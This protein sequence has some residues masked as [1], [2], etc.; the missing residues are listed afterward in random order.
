MMEDGHCVR[1]YSLQAC[2][3]VDPVRNEVFQATTLRMLIQMVA[4]DLGI[5]LM[6]RSPLTR[7]LPRRATSC[8]D[9]SLRTSR[10]GPSRWPGGKRPPA[11]QNSR[12]LEIISAHA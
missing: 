6:R 2:R 3:I 12:R 8:S 10:F 5:T 4:A 9:R 1:G 11:A 7:N